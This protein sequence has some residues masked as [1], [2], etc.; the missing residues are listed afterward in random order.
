MDFHPP[1]FLSFQMKGYKITC[2]SPNN[3]VIMN[4][5]EVV[6]I[7]FIGTSESELAFLGQKFDIATEFYSCPSES[8]EVGI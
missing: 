3:C 7:N 1:S 4:S 6:V 5:G 2:K 8:S